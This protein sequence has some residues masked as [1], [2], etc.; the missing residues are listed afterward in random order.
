M[1][2]LIGPTA[3]VASLKFVSTTAQNVTLKIGVGSP[4][5]LIH[6]C[7]VGLR[8]TT[9]PLLISDMHHSKIVH[10]CRLRPFLILLFLPTLSLWSHQY[11]T[12]RSSAGSIRGFPCS[13]RLDE[14]NNIQENIGCKSLKENHRTE[15]HVMW[16]SI[17]II[18]LGLS[19]SVKF[20]RI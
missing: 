1:F 10:I 13:F 8:F 4:G 3:L 15:L 2:Q 11:I 19:C 12:S 14:I 20:S 9:L 5:D 17:K 6:I 7:S 16:I 18:I